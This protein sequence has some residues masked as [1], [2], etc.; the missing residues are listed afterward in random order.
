MSFDPLGAYKMMETRTT[1]PSPIMAMEEAFL[2]P[3][4]YAR[5][6]REES[7]KLAIK[8]GLI[9]DDSNKEDCE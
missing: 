7:H 2:Y 5:I 4:E 8:M 6:Q 9:P 3:E 1:S